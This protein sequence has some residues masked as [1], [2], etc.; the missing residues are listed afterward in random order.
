MRKSFGILL[1]FFLILI[2]GTAYAQAYIPLVSPSVIL[3]EQSTG[4]MLY[5]KNENSKMYPASM[6]KILTALVAA[7]Y[8][9]PDDIVTVGAEIYGLPA[10]YATNIH[11]EGETITVRNLLRA[12]M[13]ASCNETGSVLAVNTVRAMEGR[14]DIPFNEAERRF[15][16][17]MNEKAISL[18]A[19]SSN[20]NNTYGLHSEGHFTTAADMALI[21]RAY[22][23]N[24]LLASIAA[25]RNYIGDSL[26]GRTAEGARVN[27]YE[28][29]NHNEL[30]L[31]GTNGYQY[32]TGIKTGFTD[33]AGD[34][35]AASATRNGISLISVV[36]FSSCGE[37]GVWVNVSF[38]S[39]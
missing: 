21:A 8:L 37:S 25:E 14:Y 35:L 36:F 24:D 31:G 26:E 5:G 3:V 30:L 18:G 23:G 28:W 10:D 20:F 33:E 34:C 27:N 7:E 4:K 9:N 38:L 22:M 19:L 39:I 2:P 1:A 6:T 12:L 15:I 29:E 13:I 11:S 16:Q 32:A 17:L